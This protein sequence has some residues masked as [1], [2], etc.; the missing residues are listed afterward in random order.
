MRSSEKSSNQ[1]IVGGSTLEALVARAEAMRSAGGRLELWGDLCDLTPQL[2]SAESPCTPP[3]AT[4]VVKPDDAERSV[5]YAMGM[6]G[7]ALLTG[8]HPWQQL[9]PTELRDAILSRSLPSIGEERAPAVIRG[10][11]DR[12]I[13]RATSK[14]PSARHANR[15]ELKADLR[16]VIAMLETPASE[17]IAGPAIREREFNEI[18]E[19]VDSVRT[20]GTG[21]LEISGDSGT[22]KTYLWETVVDASA[23]PDERWLY[24]KAGP[25]ERR[26]YDTISRLLES[27]ADEIASLLHSRPDL[28]PL[29]AFVRTIAPALS[30][31]L[32][33]RPGD[34]SALV[35]EPA[36]SLARLLSMAGGA[37]RPSI[38][39]IDDYQWLDEYSRDAVHELMG[40]F[41]GVAVVVITRQPIE[42]ERAF[43]C[44]V[45]PAHVR[46]VTLTALSRDDA[47]RFVRT[48][49]PD[50]ATLDDVAIDR[51]YRE[52]MGNP[53]A[54]MT[55]AR[56]EARPS[57]AVSDDV[58]GA[59][60][61]ERLRRLSEPA[62]FLAM[63]ASLAAAGGGPPT[64]LATAADRDREEDAARAELIASGVMRERRDHRLRFTHDSVEIAARTL[65]LRDEKAVRTAVGS[66][67][68]QARGGDMRAAYAAAELLDVAG[69]G[70]VT[71]QTRDWVLLKAARRSLQIL[72][73]L[74]AMK[75]VERAVAAAGDDA[76]VP[77]LH[78]GHEAAY[79]LGDRARMSHYYR[80]IASAGTMLDRA[81]ARYMWIRRNYAESRFAGAAQIT[82]R[83]LDMLD[84][85]DPPIA[86]WDGMDEAISY[87]H[88]LAPGRRLKRLIDRG[89]ATDPT[90]ELASRT[91]AHMLV[92]TMTSDRDRLAMIAYAMFRIAEAYGW[93]SYT[94]L[95]FIAWGG[96][97][98][99]QRPAGAWIRPYFQCADT[100]ASRVGDPVARSTIRTLVTG[101]GSSW[102]LP[103]QEFARQLIEREQ[104]GRSAANWEYVAHAR[105]L[106]AQAMLYG[107]APLERVHKEFDEIRKEVETFGLGR[108]AH[109]L[110]KHHQAV[111]TLMGLGDDPVRMD[112]RI[113]REAPYLAEVHRT[114]DTLSLAGYHIV[115]S[116]VAL[117][118]DR[119]EV[120]VESIRNGRRASSAAVFFHDQLMGSFL[121]GVATYRCGDRVAGDAALRRLRGLARDVPE[122]N[123]HRLD[124][125]LGERA[126]GA[127]R[128]R[129]A[130]GRFRRAARRALA[131]EVL[132]E[133]AYAS[134]R[135]GDVT[136]DLRWWHQ[137][138]SLY[139][140]WGGAH[141]SHRVQEK[142]GLPQGLSTVGRTD[143]APDRFM[144]DLASSEGVPEFLRAGA[145]QLLRM[146]SGVEAVLQLRSQE[147]GQDH[148]VAL[149]GGPT[150]PNA[151]DAIA[152]DLRLLLD[153]TERGGCRSLSP[154]D[155][156]GRTA[157]IIV[158]RAAGTRGIEVA[159]LVVGI[160]GAAAFS[161]GL[162]RSIQGVLEAAASLA[163]AVE[164]RGLLQESREEL[165]RTRRQLSRTERYRRQLFSTISDAF[166]LADARASVLFSNRAAGRYLTSGENGTLVVRPEIRGDVLD[167]ISAALEHGSAPAQRISFNRS[168][169]QVKAHT[170]GEADDLVAVSL[171]DISETVA[172]EQRL[173][174]KD[175]QLVVS[176]RLASIGMF[177]S[178]IVHEISNPNHVLQLNTQSLSMVLSWLRLEGASVEERQA[179]EQARELGG[180]IADAARRVE[181]VLQMVKSYGREGRTEQWGPLDPGGVCERAFRFSRIMA[182]QHTDDFTLS[183]GESLPE[184]W[185][186]A[187]L[188]EQAVVNLIKNACDA[189]EDRSGSVAVRA[190]AQPETVRIAVCDTGRGFPEGVRERIGTPFL[191]ARHEEGGTGLGLSIVA[192]IVDKHGGR[193]T[194]DAV[195]GF[196]TRV[197]LELPIHRSSR[198]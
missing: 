145:A 110:A 14:D 72:A 108:T 141:A 157:P 35:P 195:G 24:A 183:V 77:L 127:G 142:L 176:D 170:V 80:A 120:V 117:Y 100:L 34:T 184:V 27:R 59:V 165:S 143:V 21:L 132:H 105:H 73:P 85:V 168:Y 51:L 107:G 26:P 189:L 119:P 6:L 25:G 19:W 96:Y 192:S 57:S 173:A 102:W 69:D 92:P 87:A 90:A 12:L 140:L 158:G 128:Y 153:E 101:L 36:G 58:L 193:L 23:R 86:W 88:A 112:G 114:Q 121:I 9:A 5:V 38:V 124:I 123:L 68:A 115:K 66:L 131:R 135:L 60:A 188:L 150:A 106:H 169:V 164:L 53:M 29:S 99:I 84:V 130:A 185:G 79:V 98:G 54:L 17:T 146:S 20:G 171:Y 62:R 194:V 196:S 178:A 167:M 83:V 44:S 16:N 163:P 175:R 22:G 148:H 47:R 136:H 174:N 67:V 147:T 186:D 190:T 126:A 179:V 45:S 81:Q 162:V 10:R 125:V 97:V 159:G 161:D 144:A 118:A 103:Y 151:H 152:P 182:S 41:R 187:A 4:G 89:P 138:E 113:I 177:S 50:D 154:S 39:C 49:E 197:S 78:V 3:E 61:A 155:L 133:A 109:A 180:Q 70:T 42:A 46:R 65:A 37:K 93:T 40:A 198:D 76:R 31:V 32:P 111:E 91:L 166:L 149:T 11:I 33:V 48:L 94:G 1:L 137:A 28:G 104:E 139:R 156:P 18:R 82:A 55:L 30:P 95:G 2:P 7:Y 71:P 8:G 13:A 160:P 64:R 15:G 75:L 172:N 134:E 56:S 116:L 43:D 181:S 191:S 74:D 52:S 129:R 122:T 63:V